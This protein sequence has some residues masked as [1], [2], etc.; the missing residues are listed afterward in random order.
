[1]TN[2]ILDTNVRYNTSPLNMIKSLLLQLLD[3]KVGSHSLLS[4]IKE[5]MEHAESG[6][7]ANEIEAILWKAFEASLDDRK[8]LVLI[9]G[10]DHLSGS[11]IGNP[12]AL[13]KLDDITRTKRN[14]KAIL[15]SRPVCAAALK[16]C[17]EHI[18]LETTQQASEDIE[19]FVQDFLHHRSGFGHLKETEKHDI[20]KE[21]AAAAHGSFLLAGL[22]LRYADD[23][24]SVTDIL[25]VLKSHKTVEEVL[26]REI[27]SLDTKRSETKHILAW[28]VAAERPLTL[29]EVK[30][31]LEVDLDGCA[32]RPFSGDIEKT[33]RKLCGSLVIVRD[34][35][36]TFRHPSI[37]ERLVTSNGSKHV[38]DT[39]EAHRELTIRTMAYVKIYLQHGDMDPLA[40][41]YDRSEI[42][43]SFSKH[44]LFE[45]AARYWVTHFRSSTM[46]D[47]T[48][49]MF[50]LPAQFKIA[51][52]NAT[53]LA[54]FEGSCIARQYIACEAEKLQN[55][56]YNIRKT[57]FGKHSASA[58]QSL[59]LELRIGR[60][61][62]SAIA[63]C[64]YSFEAWEMS[65]TICS[66]AVIQSLAEAF[67]G[68]SRA[69]KISE[70]S[71]LYTRKVEVLEWLVEA[72][73]HSHNESKE[74]RYLV[75][76]AEL[77]I[78]TKHT[79]KAVII[80]RRLYRLRLQ[81]HGH[82]HEETHSLF[83]LL[84]TYL[85]QL[86][87]HDE[88][89]SLYLEYHQHCEQTLVITDERRIQSTL[90]IV[91]FYEERQEVFKAEQVLVRFWRHV[92]IAK[93]TSRITELKI[94][95]ALK[96]SNFLFRH[97]RNEES[98]VILRGV[99]TEIQ[100][101]SYEARFESSMIKR[102]ETIASYFSK[103]EVY[104]M[105]RSIYQSLYEHY[106]SHEQRTST[107][108]ITIVRTLAETITKS[109]K[110]SK[111]V[112]KSE[113][114]TKMSTTTIASKE[115]KTLL[116]LFES[117]LESTEITSTTISVCQALCSSY[118]YEERYKEACAIYSRVVKKV[119]ASIETTTVVD[120]TEITES[121][122]EE[123]FE[124][125]VSLAV[126]HFKMLRVDV[127]VSCYTL[128]DRT[129]ANPTIGNHLHEP[130]P[131]P[132]L[133][134]S[135]REQALS[136]RQ[137]QGRS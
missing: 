73:Q 133:Y 123:I 60:E 7:P 84:V 61:F 38:I 50:N 1:V 49:G 137:D 8:L 24:A 51:F 82:L 108:C 136:S 2:C 113:T 103:L 110:Q 131:R 96:Y 19:H 111:T 85:R 120:V 11:R 63:L 93:S 104:S 10:L 90:A 89:M 127:T 37:R 116:E 122:T 72:Y 44:D 4:H 74:L 46:Y 18:S 102:V 107:E 92:S 99:Y 32:Y 16:H 53:R 56:V 95:F 20:V 91:E 94:E 34:G 70:H 43:S 62:K 78:E 55:L 132:D 65:R 88:V 9:D 118:M 48:T 13:E 126:C 21:Y 45:Y 135:H 17:Q 59:I 54:L 71:E 124:L 100:S 15:L 98:E 121:F 41:L 68:H 125:A 47:K 5:A 35:L 76:L 101:Y 79:D 106:E 12:P 31:L 28:L 119:W 14:V 75:I 6:R 30:A 134:T 66:I 105:S 3:R 109:I 40:D 52:S 77:Y 27:A 128:F 81:A 86:S 87:F 69:L 58:L 64:E 112:T 39:K 83:K 42:A 33:V 26:D 22:Q 117:S 129:C 114:T 115:E 130:L 25:K 36:V 97:S 57:L 80:Y 29:R 67:V 23:K